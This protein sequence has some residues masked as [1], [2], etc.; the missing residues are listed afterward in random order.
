MSLAFFYK[1]AFPLRG[2]L[3]RVSSIIRGDQIAEYLGAKANP[4]NGYEDDIC[5]HVKPHVKRDETSYTFRGH[6]VVDVIDG[7]DLRFI[8]NRYPQ[9]P[10]IVCS[11][12]SARLFLHYV[13][14]RLVIIPQH[15]CNYERV[16]RERDRVQTVGVIGTDGAFPLIPPEIQQAVAARGLTWLECRHF[17]TRQDI[18]AFYRQVDVQ[19]VWR[20]DRRRHAP[21]R[22]PLKL[23]NA[24]SFGIP[25]IALDEPSF[26]EVAGCY[27]PVA[28]VAEFAE[29][30]DALAGSAALYTAYAR[31][32][33]QMA[34]AYHIE[35]VAA[36]YRALERDERQR[37]HLDTVSGC[38]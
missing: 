1:P 14:N 30:L 7:F 20:P 35:Q 2:H 32:C 12:Y 31:R 10:A 38:A 4:E 18:V 36:R 3:Q 6:P 28:T 27:A 33:R 15:H 24:A 34:E 8:L 23:I 29:Q 25:T 19:L 22:N 11:D 26:V 9:V 13:P 17:A 16:G 5:I 21:L 37:L